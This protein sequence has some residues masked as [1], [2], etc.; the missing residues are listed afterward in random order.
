M[1]L[2]LITFLSFILLGCNVKPPIKGP[3][4][5]YLVE[6][7]KV[8][9][10]VPYRNQRSRFKKIELPYADAKSFTVLSKTE[11]TRAPFGR[12]PAL[13]WAKDSYQVYYGGIPLPGSKPETLQILDKRYSKDDKNV[14]Y[15]S[16]LLLNSDSKS[17]SIIDGPYSKDKNNVYYHDNTLPYA[18][19]KSFKAFVFDNIWNYGYAIDNKHLYY[20]GELKK[21]CEPTSLEILDDPSSDWAKDTQCIYFRGNIIKDTDVDTFQLLDKRYAKDKNKVFYKSV[22]IESANPATFNIKKREYIATDE[23]RCYLSGKLVDCSTGKPLIKRQATKEELVLKKYNKGKSD[24]AKGFNKLLFKDNENK[25]SAFLKLSNTLDLMR[26]KYIEHSLSPS[27]VKNIDL[28]KLPIGAS[29]KLI[30]KSMNSNNIMTIRLNALESNIAIFNVF[31][32][33]RFVKIPEIRKITGE[34]ISMPWGFYSKQT[35]KYSKNKCQYQLGTCIHKIK[36]KQEITSHISFKDGIWI[37]KSIYPGNK[38]EK[39]TYSIFDKFGFPLF[40]AEVSNN[41]LKKHIER[42]PPYTF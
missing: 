32:K 20:R 24:L 41:K 38:E 17:F 28:S 14:F 12:G 42:L 6:G 2:S 39:I 25:K 16:N 18:D 35:I 21:S 4:N 29:Y 9:L 11:S 15:E 30:N 5:I 27:D 13:V 10:K 31:I 8:L 7:Q 36:S 19:P 3:Y 33:N 22:H 34:I 23:D 37:N 1:K 26:E 40:I